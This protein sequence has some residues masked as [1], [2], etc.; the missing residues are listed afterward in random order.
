VAI[1]VGLTYLSRSEKFNISTVEVFGNKVIDGEQIKAVVENNMS[2]YYLW[3]FPKSNFLLY[4]K[5]RI[6]RDLQMQFRRLKDISF[7][8]VGRKSLE[9]KLNERE[10]KYLW[11]GVD[12]PQDMSTTE[13]YFMDSSGYIFDNAPY[14]SGDIYFKFF[15]P[16][17]DTTT[18]I[19]NTFE[20]SLFG[21][22]TTFKDSLAALGVKPSTIYLSP[23]GEID[24]YM[25]SNISIPNAPKII[26]KVDSNLEKIIENLQAALDTEPLKTD[27]VKKYKTLQY[28]DL[29]FGNKVYYKFAAPA[30]EVA[31]VVL[32]T[33]P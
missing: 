30:V 32:P 16:V 13:C 9:V 29:S 2:G 23:D 3:L 28:I 7:N 11:C 5:T 12:L 18:P 6:E 19:G 21:S 15:G 14:F 33:T 24:L 17:S 10:G 27:F 1:L 25:S 20:P 8:V 22:L 4:P 26:F 31:P